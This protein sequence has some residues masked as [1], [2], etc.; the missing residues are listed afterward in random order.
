MQNFDLNLY[1]IF[2]CVA[3]TKS[4]TKAAEQ[5]VVSRQAVSYSI[6]QLESALGGQLF[7]RSVK[8]VE[9]TPEAEELYQHIKQSLEMISIGERIFKENNGL[10]HGTINIGCNPELFENCLYP[11]VDKFFKLYPNIKMNIISKPI[12]DLLKMFK[13]HKLDLIV[14]KKFTDKVTYPNL[15]IKMFSTV[16]N[17]FFVNRDFNIL[18]KRKK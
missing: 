1:Q 3:E 2:C 17:C 12:G 10:L 15:S 11:Y 14:R 6:K 18:Q 8:G 13:E 7:F 5:L 9:L 16:H 4:I